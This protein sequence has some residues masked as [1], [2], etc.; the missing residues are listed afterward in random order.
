MKLMQILVAGW[1]ALTALGAC[2]QAPS[3]V[4]VLEVEAFEKRL[5]DTPNALLLDV[6]T[7]AEYAAGH[8]PNAQNIDYNAPDFEARVAAL[9]RSQP[10]FVYCAVG[11]R[12]AK[13]GRVL[14]RLGFVSVADLKGGY[15]AFKAKK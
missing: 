4:Q 6:R 2:A 5:A 14:E 8:L 15:N 10:V 13:A 12:S 11:G 9:D 3:Q 1:A 7:P